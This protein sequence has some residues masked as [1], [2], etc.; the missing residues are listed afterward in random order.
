MA[1]EQLAGKEVSTKSDI[2]ALG[3][4]LYEVFTGKRAFAEK[5]AGALHGDLDRTPSRPSSVVK[6][7]DPIIEKVILRCLETEPSSRPATALAVAAAL[8]GGDPLAA[9]LAA[10]E[11]P[12]PQMV[13]AAGEKEGL[14]PPL[15]VAIRRSDPA[16]P[17]PR[18]LSFDPLQRLREDGVGIDARSSDSEIARAHL[19]AGLSGPSN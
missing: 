3:L 17:F 9:A 6:D 4:V 11:T 18:G 13:A 14:R 16:G 12:S 7:L 2:Y 5:M 1:P 8:P 19:P 15:A 10:G